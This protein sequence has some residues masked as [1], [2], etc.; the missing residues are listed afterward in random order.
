[1]YSNVLDLWCGK[2][3]LADKS[4]DA[5]MAMASVEDRL[6]MTEVVTAI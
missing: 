1:M 2:E 4:L 6:E 3:G 5:A